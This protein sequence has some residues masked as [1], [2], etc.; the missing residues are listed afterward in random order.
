MT[1]RATINGGEI[2]P[3]ALLAATTSRVSERTREARRDM[4]ERFADGGAARNSGD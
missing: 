4:C 1:R 2:L 3:Q